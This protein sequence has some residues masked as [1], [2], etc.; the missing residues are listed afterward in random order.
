M[1][2][3]RL[4]V[5]ALS[6]AAAGP[7]LRRVIAG[8]AAR[9]AGLLAKSRPFHRQIGDGRLALEVDLIQTLAEDLNVMLTRRD[10]LSENVHHSKTDIAALFV[11]RLPGFALSRMMRRR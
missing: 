6:D 3:E 1:A 8:L 9:N 7:A 11:K 10:P 4:T 5:T 2:A